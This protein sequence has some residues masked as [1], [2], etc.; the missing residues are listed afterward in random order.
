MY[1]TVL[2]NLGHS[3]WGLVIL[4][5]IISITFKIHCPVFNLLSETLTIHY[6]FLNNRENCCYDSS[7]F[8]SHGIS[9]L[10]DLVISLADGVASMYLEFISV[11]SD[12]SSETN[13]LD[14]SLCMFST[15]EL[16]KLRNEVLY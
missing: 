1:L 8:S 12:L 15:R 9:I 3:L 14:L 4:F 6:F 10:E 11:D 7:L 2:F 5:K 13:G 16:Q